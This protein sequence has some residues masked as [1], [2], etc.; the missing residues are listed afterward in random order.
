MIVIKKLLKNSVG[1]EL[2]SDDLSFY[3]I[4]ADKVWVKLS[5]DDLV[6]W[7]RFYFLN[8]VKGGVK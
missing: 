6:S 3:L 5:D 4:Y 7:L 8:D 2:V 1:E